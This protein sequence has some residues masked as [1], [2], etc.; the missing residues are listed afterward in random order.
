MS[1]SSEQR[2][3][4]Y[5]QSSV[6]QAFAVPFKFF[7]ASDLKVVRTTAGVDFD[8]VL[9]TDYTV[10]IA[11][12]PPAALG[13]VTLVAGTIGDM[14]TIYGAQPVTQAVD[15]TSNGPLPSATLTAQLDKLVIDV[16]QQGIKIERAA[17]GPLTQAPFN[18]SVAQRASRLSGWDVLGNLIAY[19]L[20]AN[21]PT[22]AS[23]SF[24]LATGST[25]QRLL[26]SRFADSV[27]VK[28]FGAT[29]DGVS[30]DTVAVLA[31]IASA[32]ARKIV[33][34]DF[35]SG[36]YV[37]ASQL[38]ITAPI[39][40]RGQGAGFLSFAAFPASV[41]TRIKWGGGA[42]GVI[43]FSNVNFGGWGIKGIDI[44]CN[45]VGTNGLIVSDCVGGNFDD[46][47]VRN[48]TVR[49]LHLR[50]TAAYLGNTNSWHRFYGMNID[51]L[52]AGVAEAIRCGGYAGG[53]NACH[54]T[55]VN[56]R[57]THGGTAHGIVLGGCDNI[58]FMMT[59]IYRAGG[60]TG[61][62]VTVDTTEIAGFPTANTFMLLQAG[63]GGYYDSVG[64]SQPYNV[65]QI[66]GYA[67]DNGQPPIYAPNGGVSGFTNA[68]QPLGLI[69]FGKT[70]G[71][72]FDLA[73][74]Y[75]AGATSRVVNFPSAEPDGNYHIVYTS[76]QRITQDVWING[77]TAAGFTVNFSADPGGT[78]PFRF[79]VV[80]Y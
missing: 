68:G 78:V 37:L 52:N 14:I 21:S 64:P 54:I 58:L 51:S 45:N 22:D 4:Q 1:I 20:P 62:G 16:Q 53:G 34:V 46:V 56:S 79:L 60:G 50:S 66:F 19:S 30:N 7:L 55:F 80:R 33:N 3:V 29:G 35:P 25:T 76:T 12:T 49:G 18:P 71:A 38:I 10:T 44:D 43:T 65:S 6:A 5:T 41:G 8:L 32:I 23:S 11:A 2:L 61:R 27:N 63:D 75:A 15:F 36:T 57:V 26:S 9:T 70:V 31:A 48:Y 42:T 13:T 17:R 67:L 28:D 59:Y 77:Y 73:Y 69:S 24:V 47:G 39:L 40:L 72:N 74:N